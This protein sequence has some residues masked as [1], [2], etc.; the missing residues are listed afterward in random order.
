ME[1]E[2]LYYV[3][4]EDKCHDCW[5]PSPLFARQYAATVADTFWAMFRAG[6]RLRKVGHRMANSQN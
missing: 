3:C 2:K 6:L 1:A 5:R 4:Q